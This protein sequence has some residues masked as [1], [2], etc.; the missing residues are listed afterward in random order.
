MRIN[1]ALS[2][3]GQWFLS[4]RVIFRDDWSFY[5]SNEKPEEKGSNFHHSEYEPKCMIPESHSKKNGLSGYLS[6]C[7][8]VSMD[9]RNANHRDK[10]G[11]QPS[12]YTDCV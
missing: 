9:W 6:P 11:S 2:N 12:R 8:T 7:A 4:I 10:A 3:A 5:S 1:N